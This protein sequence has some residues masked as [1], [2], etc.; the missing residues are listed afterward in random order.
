MIAAEEGMTSEDY[1]LP[2]NPIL[3]FLGMIFL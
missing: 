3:K 1:L 2:V